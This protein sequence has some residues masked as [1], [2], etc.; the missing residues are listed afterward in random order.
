MK[1]FLILMCCIAFGFAAKAQKLEGDF[2]VLLNESR[3]DFELSFANARIHGMTET[4]FAKYEDGWHKDLR[5]I[6]GY[7]MDN[8]NNGVRKLVRFSSY[9][10][11]KYKLKVDVLDVSTRGSFDSDAILLDNSGNVVAKISGLQTDGGVFGTKLYLIKCGASCN[12]DNLGDILYRT[13][14]KL[15]RNKK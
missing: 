10:T 3:V 8:L 4:E 5:E 11:A 7:F 1:R 6:V 2:A 12:G 9:P 15:K 13:L 14:K